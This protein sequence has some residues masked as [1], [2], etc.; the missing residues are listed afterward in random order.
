MTDMETVEQ[1][2][3]E[4]TTRISL[5]EDTVQEIQKEK[6]EARA[7]LLRIAAKRKL[8]VKTQSKNRGNNAKP[9]KLIRDR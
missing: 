9:K 4:L 7:A 8:P 1:D 3:R 6:A 5:L 2:I